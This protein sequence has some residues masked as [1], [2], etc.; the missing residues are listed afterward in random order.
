MSMIRLRL[1]AVVASSAMAGSMPAIGRAINY[2][3]SSSWALARMMVLSHVDLDGTWEG[4]ERGMARP[5][6]SGRQPTPEQQREIFDLV[7]KGL[8]EGA[9]GIGAPVGYVPAAS[10]E[11]IYELA[12]I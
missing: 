3:Y 6:W 7:E 1:A 11:E 2:G 4:M 9:I 5:E 10:H 8:D 12:K